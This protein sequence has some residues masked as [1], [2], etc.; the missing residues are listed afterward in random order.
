MTFE[1][2]QAAKIFTGVSY[3]NISY[4]VRGK[5]KTAGGYHW[6]YAET[7]QKL[8]VIVCNGFCN[9]FAWYPNYNQYSKMLEF[10]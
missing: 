8:S 7:S 4:V 5:S 3:K 9:G 10:S 2:A 1:T 6:E